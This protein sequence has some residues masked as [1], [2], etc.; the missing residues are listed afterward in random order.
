[1]ETDESD[2]C[3]Y[4][5][6]DG[7]PPNTMP[8]QVTRIQDAVMSEASPLFRWQTEP[9]SREWLQMLEHYTQQC[10]KLFELQRQIVDVHPLLQ[11]LYPVAIVVGEHFYIFDVDASGQAYTFV[12]QAPTPMPVPKGVRAAFPLEC[13][14]AKSACVVTDDVFDTLD[15]YVTL[16]HEFVHC[17]QAEACEEKLKQTLHIAQQAKA[18]NDVMWELNYPFPYTSA[19][20]VKAYTTFLEAAAQ[21]SPDALEDCRAHLRQLLD[22]GAFEYMVWQ[23]WKEGF[24]RYIENRIKRRLGLPE[25]H[26]G[27]EVPFSRVTFYEGGARLI[28][29]LASQ[30]P[31]LLLDIGKLFYR[32]ESGL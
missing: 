10:Q 18:E 15:G 1:M 4:F 9:S 11:T 12:K 28:A 25:N 30:E 7:M 31:A 19:E 3:R 22:A 20:F 5:A 8:R 17:Y 23:E 2:A 32:M 16:F 14:G 29:Y 13:Y 27:A 21:N 26:G 24:A 6:L